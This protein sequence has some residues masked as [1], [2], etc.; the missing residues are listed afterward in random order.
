MLIVQQGVMTPF[1][2]DLKEIW[3]GH[4]VQ[5]ERNHL[6]TFPALLGGINDMITETMTVKSLSLGAACSS[7]DHGNLN[8]HR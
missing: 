2:H 5:C 1:T 8:Q 3:S 4:F 7:I 6:K